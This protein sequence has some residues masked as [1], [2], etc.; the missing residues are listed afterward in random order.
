MFS[1]ELQ[2]WFWVQTV[3]T[4]PIRDRVFQIPVLMTFDKRFAEIVPALQARSYVLCGPLNL[5]PI[6]P[7]DAR[8]LISLF[9]KDP[10]EQE[11]LFHPARVLARAE[12]RTAANAA[13]KLRLK[14]RLSSAPLGAPA[15][16][17]SVPDDVEVDAVVSMPEPISHAANVRP[18][19]ARAPARRR[20]PP[21]GTRPPRDVQDNALRRRVGGHHA[22]TF[23]V[24]AS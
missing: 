19:L 9:T 11:V 12:R 7:L 1:W 8:D 14:A 4:L 24:Q 3:L 5:Q 18:G 23:A 21:G 17:D 15:S 2:H 10:N 20:G 22:R 16:A 13:S 6:Y